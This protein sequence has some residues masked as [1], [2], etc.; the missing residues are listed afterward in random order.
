MIKNQIWSYCLARLFDAFLLLSLS[1]LWSNNL[2]I[3]MPFIC[4]IFC[5]ISWK[6]NRNSSFLNSR[7]NSDHKGYLLKK[8]FLHMLIAGQS[9]YFHLQIKEKKFTTKTK[10]TNYQMKKHSI[11][12]IFEIQDFQLLT[13]AQC[14]LLQIFI[15]IM[16]FML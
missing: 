10:V 1:F 16:K 3:R 14:I 6:Q 9:N 5:S 4:T 8:C 13:S 15:N 11:L 2:G 12:V 7:N